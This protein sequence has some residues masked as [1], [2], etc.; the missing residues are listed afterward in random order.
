M[1]RG[2]SFTFLLIKAPLTASV[3]P[4]NPLSAPC[5]C[6]FAAKPSSLSLSHAE[7]PPPCARAHS[8]RMRISSSIRPMRLPPWSF[9]QSS[10]RATCQLF[11]FSGVAARRCAPHTRYDGASRQP[12]IAKQLSPSL[13]SAP[14]SPQGQFLR[15]NR[16]HQRRGP[17]P[18]TFRMFEQTGFDGACGVFR[19]K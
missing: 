12:Q 8:L 6:V 19:P 4:A 14:P 11:P 13:A 5:D 1:G 9:P 17:R 7:P 15:V 3:S 18:M 10:R 2:T 16:I